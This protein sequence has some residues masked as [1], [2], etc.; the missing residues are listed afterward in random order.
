M[1]SQVNKKVG[2]IVE[3]R[4]KG[5]IESVTYQREDHN[6]LTC[7]VHVKL[8]SGWHQ[9]F[10]GLLLDEEVTGPDF[11]KSLCDTFGVESKDQLVGLSCFALRCWAIHNEPIEG[12]EA[13]SGK[14]FILTTWR[15]RHFPNKTQSVL[16][17]RY[18]KKLRHLESTRNRVRELE[19][20]L[21]YLPQGYIDWENRSLVPDDY[22]A[23]ITVTV[24]DSR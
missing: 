23:P 8:D 21:T 14:R 5:V 9:G 15:R 13:T 4:D 2:V 11:V 17:L 7:F 18:E 1:I 6:I 10:G 19:H 12:L 24:R 16:E 20:E 22:Q 3:T